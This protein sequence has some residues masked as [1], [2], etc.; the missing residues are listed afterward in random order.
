MH[1]EVNP[2]R[3][4]LWL[5]EVRANIDLK[6]F[7]FYCVLTYLDAHEEDLANKDDDLSVVRVLTKT[8]VRQQA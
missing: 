5:H 3:D 8:V 6:A 7:E 1:E 2:G 4:F